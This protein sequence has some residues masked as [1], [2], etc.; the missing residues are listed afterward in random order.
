M[1]FNRFNNYDST[2]HTQSTHRS[3]SW[4][5]SNDQTPY[6][7]DTLKLHFAAAHLTHLNIN[8]KITKKKLVKIMQLLPNLDSFK[9]LSVS[10][11]GTNW[12]IKENGDDVFSA[13][14][15][16]KITKINIEMIKNIEQVH[17]LLYLCRHTQY[18]QVNI[19]KEMDLEG[20][21]RFILIKASTYI[22]HLTSFCIYI[23]N[24]DE[25]MLSLL[26]KLIDTEELSP[27]FMIKFVGNKIFLKCKNS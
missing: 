17:F 27:Y 20:L 18:F 9:L 16:I 22:L 10:Y 23:P 8:H 7:I 12:L 25:K 11:V 5:P 3:I 1:P 21:V 13:S 24:A 6:F 19:P 15:N 4:I 26:Q 14:I 2:K